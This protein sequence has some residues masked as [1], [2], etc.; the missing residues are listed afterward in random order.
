MAS[1]TASNEP[2]Y[3]GLLDRGLAILELLS[4]CADGLSLTAI[5]DTL[6]IPRSATHRLLT[7]LSDHEYVRQEQDRGDYVLTTKL[8]ALAFRHLA[9]LG[10][11]DAAQQVLDRLATETGELV[12]LAVADN[13]QLTWVAKAQG[14]RA[15]LRYDPEMGMVAKLSCSATGY[16]WLSRMSDEDAVAILQAQG[17]GTQADF[18]PQAPQTAAEVLKHI[19]AARKR[20]YAVAVQTF[21]DWMAAIATPLVHP[22]SKQPIGVIS[23]AGP[24]TRLPEKRLHELA[25]LLVA[26]A[27]EISQLVPGSPSLTSPGLAAAAAREKL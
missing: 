15:G 23:L 4:G 9:S 21:S 19:H 6:R 27:A 3:S 5:S 22:L 14:A 18:G 10:Y 24:L 1:R 17:Y 12:R 11:M 25:P 8:Q 26:A 7:S 20:G 16:A 2:G 13:G